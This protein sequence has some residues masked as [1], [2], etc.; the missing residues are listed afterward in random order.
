MYVIYIDRR[1]TEGDLSVPPCCGRNTSLLQDELRRAK[2]IFFFGPFVFSSCGL[3]V[4]VEK[5]YEYRAKVAAEKRFCDLHE[6]VRV[7]R[8]V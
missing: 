1:V 8:R 6:Y 3:V 2:R 5:I 7:V 4:D